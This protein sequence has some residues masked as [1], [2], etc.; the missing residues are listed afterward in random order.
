MTTLP[1]VEPVSYSVPPYGQGAPVDENGDPIFY[2][3]PK[4]FEEA[5]N[6]GER[7]QALYNELCEVVPSQRAAVLKTRAYEARAS[8]GVTTLA[9]Y[10]VWRNLDDEQKRAAALASLEELADNETV[11]RLANGVRSFTLP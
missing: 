4:S 6:D 2:H 10:N 7:I 5:A 8:Y 9:S 1:E 11:A 3:A